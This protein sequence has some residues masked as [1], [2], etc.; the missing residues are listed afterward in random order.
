[1]IGIGHR[2]K[3]VA[4]CRFDNR[5]FYELNFCNLLAYT[6]FIY[7]KS[8]IKSVKL[9]CVIIRKPILTVQFLNV[10]FFTFRSPVLGSPKF[11]ALIPSQSSV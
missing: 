5:A 11:L 3:T 8:I 7:L 2:N 6:S 9:V 10:D 1:M 4:V